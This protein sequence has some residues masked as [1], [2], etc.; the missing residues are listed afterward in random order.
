MSG[1]CAKSR[2]RSPPLAM[3]YSAASEAWRHTQLL[4]A[5][6]V[7]GRLGGA[8]RQYV[9][10]AA[11][12]ASIEFLD[13]AGRPMRPRRAIP[14]AGLPVGLEPPLPAV[15]RLPRDPKVPAGLRDLSGPAASFA[16]DFASPGPEACL[17]SFGHR[18]SIPGLWPR[19]ESGFCYRSPEI[20]QT[21]T[22]VSGR[23]TKRRCG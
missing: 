7:I 19:I 13:S 23:T 12:E 20:S 15:E 2:V 21:V 10:P 16:E 14:E 4:R 6:D 22:D 9:M 11:A 3:A 5:R 1:S 17:F 8:L 18:A